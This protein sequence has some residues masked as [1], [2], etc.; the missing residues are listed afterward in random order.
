[1]VAIRE[2]NQRYIETMNYIMES[3]GMTLE[4]FA[5]SLKVGRTTLSQVRNGVQNASIDVVAKTCIVYPEVNAN[6]ILA[7]CGPMLIKEQGVNED[8]VT[9]KELHESLEGA[10]KKI[11][12]LKDEN[13][14]LRAAFAKLQTG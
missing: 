4:S 14:L 10:M 2:H 13:E 8:E 6:Y 7:G 3:R 12:E 9:I 5:K 1:M 11:K